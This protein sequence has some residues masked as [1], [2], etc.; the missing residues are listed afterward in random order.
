MNRFALD[1]QYEKLLGHFGI[2]VDE[3]LR[4]A[5]LA[6]DIFIRRNPTV[7][8]A[9]FFRFMDAVG[10][11]ITDPQVPI[12]IASADQIEIFSPPVFA[13]YCSKNGRTCIDRLGRYKKLMGPVRYMVTEDAGILCVEIT[14]E[15]TD[16]PMPQFLVEVEI[17]FLINILRKAAKEQITPVR[18]LMQSPV[19]TSEFL[20]FA[21]CP[22]MESDRNVILYRRADMEIPFITRNDA[23]WDFFEPELKRRLSEL[24]VDDSFAVRVRSVL[25]ELLPGGRSGINDVAKK[26]GMSGRTL[27]RKLSEENTSFHQ[28]LNLTR[29]LLAKHYI[30]D[31]AMTSSDIA[32]LLGYQE[33]NSFFRAFHTWTGMSVTEY[34]QS[35]TM[36][37]DS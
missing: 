25:T 33:L 32:Y 18:L 24:E 7:T 22:V 34:R 2:N 6:E 35:P 37:H 27:Q 17:V 19:T 29:E 36:E 11:Q 1:R 3:V 14:A 31:T 4:K 23:M 15:D 20:H 8:S 10:S 28:E 30:S 26:L 9:E 16:E 21:G 13:A 5:G 12:A